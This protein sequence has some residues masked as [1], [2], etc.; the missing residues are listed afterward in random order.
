MNPT[1]DAEIIREA[2]EA[3]P[4]NAASEFGAEFRRDIAS[5]VDRA[6]VEA[7]VVSG[8]FELPPMA[9]AVYSAFVDPSGGSADSMTVAIA[10][11]NRDGRGILVAVREVRPSFSPEAVVGEFAALLKMY[12]V[13]RVIGDRYAGEWPR[14]QFRKHGIDYLPSEKTKSDIYRELLP[15]LNSGRVEL[16][17]HPRLMAQFCGLERRTARGG[18]DSIDHAPGAHDDI[19]NAAAGAL[20]AVTAKPDVVERWLRAYA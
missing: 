8:R 17:D 15:V 13:Y 10:C 18:R 16:L 6:V 12:R 4:E 19:A 7:L 1:I 5:F 20:V 14:E 11:R 9:G 3:D 2:Y